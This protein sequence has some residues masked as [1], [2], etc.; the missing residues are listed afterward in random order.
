MPSK[1]LHPTS[2][3]S[4][5]EEWANS[6]TH[7]LGAALSVAGLVVAVVLASL[8]TDAWLITAVSIYG[9]TLIILHLSS[10]LYHSARSLKWKK[11]FLSADHSSIY[12]LIAGTYT[13]FC[14]GPMRGAAGWTLFGIIWGLAVV[15][16]LREWIR[17]RRGTWLSTA[18]YL[19]MGWLVLAFLYPLVKSVTTLALVF[20]LTGGILYSIGVLFYCWHSLRFHHAIWHSFVMAGALFQF[21]AVLTLLR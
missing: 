8:R 5:V 15:G 9:S 21:L 14:L 11:V 2:G 18:I 17:P 4:R 19:A 3:Y 13:P 6:I 1:T 10:T 20:L 7:G 16:V 12:L